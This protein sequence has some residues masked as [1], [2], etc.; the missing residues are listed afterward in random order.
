MIVNLKTYSWL[1]FLFSVGLAVA[2]FVFPD[3]ALYFVVLWLMCSASFIALIH[4]A[5]NEIWTEK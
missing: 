1:L 3:L 4:I 2:F 5:A